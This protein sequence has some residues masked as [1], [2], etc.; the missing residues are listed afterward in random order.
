MPS[1]SLALLYLAILAIAQ[2]ADSPAD[3][4][5]V[6]AWKLMSYE[7][8]LA[9]GNVLKPFGEAP[10]G[11]ILYQ[12][13]GQMS[14]QLMHP[15]TASFASSNL[16]KA[17]TDEAATAWRNYIGYWGTYTIDTKASVVTH[18]I[19]G[20]SFPNWNGQKQIRSFHF[21]ENRRLMLE[22]DGPAGHATLT[23]QRID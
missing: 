11:R 1:T 19:E 3:T 18:L 14:A 21:I 17:T 22:A 4:R 6:G 15:A 12:A 5:F 7:L 2:G 8:R 20:S 23:W 9:A 10:I 13:N 16:L